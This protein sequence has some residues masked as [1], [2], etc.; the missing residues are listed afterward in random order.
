MLFCRFLQE[1]DVVKGKTCCQTK[2]ADGIFCL[3]KR[4][5]R[6]LSANH[7]CRKRLIPKLCMTRTVNLSNTQFRYQLVSFIH[8]YGYIWLAEGC[9]WHLLPRQNLW[10]H[11]L[12]RQNMV[13]QHLL[14]GGM[15]FAN[16]TSC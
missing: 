2:D 12:P 11:L 5:Q 15:I 10:W 3:G 8:I 13:R 7:I 16:T 4:C 9:L 1:R 14:T 6:Q